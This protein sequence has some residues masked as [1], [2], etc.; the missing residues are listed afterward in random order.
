MMSSLEVPLMF[1]MALPLGW[2]WLG[3][4]GM[5]GCRP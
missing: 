5:D 3:V 1:D 2:L 4:S